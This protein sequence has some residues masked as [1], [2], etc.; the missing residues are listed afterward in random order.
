M[1]RMLRFP[2]PSATIAAAAILLA[3]SGLAT[4]GPAASSVV[5]R[6][7]GDPLAGQSANRFFQEGDVDGHFAYLPGEPPHFPGDRP[8]S[9]RV[10]YDTTV[11]AGRIS[12][13]LGRVLSIDDDFSFGAI[14]TIRSGGFDAD[15]DGFDQIAFGL[16]NEATTGL[17]RTG[18]PSDS[19]DLIEFDYF[20][21]VSPLFGGP[22]LSPTVFGGDA[23][24]NAF[25]NFAFQ[26]AEVGLPFEVPLLCVADYSAATRRLMVSVSRLGSGALVQR[27]PLA[28]VVVDLAGL[29][30]GFL[31]NALGIP[32]YFEGFPSLRAVVD[33]D[34][35]YA[36]PLPAPWGNATRRARTGPQP[37]GPGQPGTTGGSARTGRTLD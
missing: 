36:G 21:N 17:D 24:G 18:F 2:G 1:T 6:F 35:L 31:A 11:P 3:P 14:L 25:F 8:G 22:F 33:Y 26:S 29:R 9:L 4:A 28:T 20:P 7:V 10:V 27:T 23:G 5:E 37:S 19:F 13:P 34:L 32:A 30:P 12:T 16:W 15:P